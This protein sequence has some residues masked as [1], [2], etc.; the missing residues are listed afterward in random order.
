[1]VIRKW[2]KKKGGEGG[3]SKDPP[4]LYDYPTGYIWPAGVKISSKSS[5]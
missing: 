3:E 5:M 2:I 1:V 4:W